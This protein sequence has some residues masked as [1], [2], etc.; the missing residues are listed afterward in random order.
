MK[1]TCLQKNTTCPDISGNTDEQYTC[2]FHPAEISFKESLFDPKNNQV[3]ESSIWMKNLILLIIGLFLITGIMAQAPQA[4]K[5]Q[6]VARDVAGNVLAN[7]MISFRISIL[8]GSTSSGAVYSETHTKST[9]SFGLIDLEIGNGT[10]V[11]G[12]I[13]D[14]DWSSNIY[15]IKIEMDPLGGSAFQMMGTSQLLSVPY[16]LHAR[17]VEVDQVDDADSDPYNEIQTLDLNG[18]LLNL[19][20]GGGT[21]LLPKPPEGDKWGDQVVQTNNS[22]SGN[23]TNDLPL[24]VV[25]EIISPLWS[26]VRNKPAGF[27]DNIDNDIDADS[28]P[29]NEIQTL[30]LMGSNLT[31]SKGG[32]TVTLP[33]SDLGDNWGTQSVQ[34]DAT[35]EGN[36]TSTTPLKIAS[37][38]ALN[39]Q[40][41]KWNGSTWLPGDDLTGTSIWTPSGDNIYYNTGK[42]GIGKDPAADL[43]RFQVLTTGEIAIAATNNSTTYPAFRA[44]NMGA[45]LAASFSNA[46]GTVAAFY[47]NLII[48]DGTQG[49][50]KVLTSD[51]TGVTSWQ[52]PSSGPWTESHS[53]IYCTGNNVGIGNTSPLALFYVDGTGNSAGGNVLFEGDL[54]TSTPASPPLSGAGTRM[55]WY[56]HKAAFRAGNVSGTQWDKASI[57]NYSTAFGFDCTASGSYSFAAGNTASATNISAVSLGYNTEAT[58]QYSLATGYSTN[59]SGNY[60]AAFNSGTTASGTASNAFGYQCTASGSYSF[61]SGFSSTASGLGSMAF[62]L[63]TT[64]SS[65]YSTAMGS[66]TTASGLYSFTCGYQSTAPSLC[67]VAVGLYNT[68]YAGNPTS[69]IS[70]DRIFVVGNGTSSAE[71]NNALI[72][73]K[74]GCVG[75]GVDAPSYTLAVSG[76]AAKTGGGSWTN[77]SDRRLKDIQG[78]YSKGLTEIVALQPVM[79]TYKKDNP[80]QLE[81]D[82]QQIGFVAQEVQAIFPEAVSENSSGYLDFN[83]HPV[84]VALVNAVKE[85]KAENDILKTAITKL[86]ERMSNLE[87]QLQVSSLK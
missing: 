3:V 49:L 35:L 34:T 67:E 15:F 38:S 77:L 12:S 13:S 63:N 46:G 37:Q 29:A 58:G 62:G 7:K 44:Q 5:Y 17:T 71:R 48:Q 72:I 59:A 11:T 18:Y 47:N 66:N 81:S 28:D 52:T 51:A 82:K 26:N 64:S 79:F 42:V 86:I 55:M 87:E 33:L 80:L 45:G 76:T 43:R 16:A 2:E 41:L 20:N 61:A 68:T 6:A 54:N 83:M 1:R 60:S 25:D 85:L 74:N 10:I 27:D 14:I 50:G 57:G 30:E 53:Y 8:P 22:L 4:F 84:N 21:V 19:S 24:K 32:G 73:L 36:G 9:N 70:T 23:G 69:L 75:I 40:T 39:G 65:N 56:P 31:L 78:Q